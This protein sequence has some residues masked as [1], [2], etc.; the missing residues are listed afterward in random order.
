MGEF[1]TVSSEILRVTFQ[2]RH[3]HPAGCVIG[4]CAN[5]SLCISSLVTIGISL[6]HGHQ[7]QHTVYG[8]NRIEFAEWGNVGRIGDD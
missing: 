8:A 3:S 1:E 6:Q 2:K 5:H 4:D 7:Q